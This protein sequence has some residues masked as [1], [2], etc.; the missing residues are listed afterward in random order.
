[1]HNPLAL[2][3][4][5]F[6]TPPIVSPLTLLKSADPA[7][8]ST[9]D[10]DLMVRIGMDTGDLAIKLQE[11]L[12]INY[13]RRTLYEEYDKARGHWMVSAALGLFADFVTTSNPLHNRTVWVT[14]DSQKYTEELTK[15]F[16]R[17]GLEEKIYDWAWTTGCYGDHFPK[18]HGQPGLG[19]TS[20]EDCFHPIDIGRIDHEG[21]LIGFY[22]NTMGGAQTTSTS[23]PL[24]PAWEYV[25]FRLLGAKK[26]R[27]MF[28]ATGAMEFRSIY[29]MSPDTRQ[30]MPKYGMYG[31]SL[32][33]DAL[34]TWKKLRLAEDSILMARLTR[35]ITRYIYK[36]KVSGD[37]QE[38]VGE[39]IDQ[40][41][42]MLKRARAIDTG[43]VSG[44]PSYDSKS[45]TMGCLIGSTGVR[46]CDGTNVAIK[47]IV[48]NKDKYIGRSVWSV[49]PETLA[50][51]SAKITRAEST[52]KDAQLIRVTL[53]NDKYIDCTPDHR[54]ML[55]D[56]TYK[57]AQN[58]RSNESIMP[59]YSKLSTKGLVGYELLYNPGTDK[60]RYAHQVVVEKVK[61]G[62]IRHHEDFNPLNNDP[63]NIKVVS[64]GKHIK[65][66]NLPGWLKGKTKE[67]CPQLI[68]LGKAVSKRM[69]AFYQTPRGKATAKRT[70][71]K[72][73]EGLASGRIVDKKLPRE[74]RECARKE[75]DNTFTAIASS[76]QKYCGNACYY[77]AKKGCDASWCTIVKAYRNKFCECGCGNQ[78]KFDSRY[79]QNYIHGH[80][81]RKAVLNHK[82]KKVEWLNNTEDTYDISVDRNFNFSLSSGIFVHNSMEDIILPVWGDVGDIS[83]DKI[84]GDPNI[85]WIVDID[86]LREQLASSLR[87]PVPLLGGHVKDAVGSLGGEALSKLDI[88]F[89]RT[90]KKLQR[91]LKEGI[92]RICQI[93]LAYMG[94]DPDVSLFEVNLSET[95]TAE[96]E[97]LK[98]SLDKGVDIID[99]YMD[100]FDKLDLNLDKS[101]LFNYLNKKI[102]KLNDLDLKDYIS[103]PVN[104]KPAIME[105]LISG[106]VREIRGKPARV[107]IFNMDF[108]AALPLKDSTKLYESKKT[109]EDAYGKTVVTETKPEEV[110]KEK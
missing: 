74:I 63:T 35:G 103:A 9:I 49:N 10:K 28:G 11:D 37:N 33:L 79:T 99:R 107:P 89:A 72:I 44:T 108:N 17:I 97:E 104:D 62:N 66:H 67:N 57:E 24:L 87:C 14:S 110:D 92:T 86:E 23:Q 90:A 95:S 55:R 32:V 101:E 65:I 69:K 76:N 68:E 106:A 30:M 84:G 75:C 93:H 41:V 85:R 38:A 56:G 47:D 91:A 50:I 109:W 70:G 82:V 73:R 77:V 39:M 18:I 45:N 27:S 42:S 100:M 78:F 12:Q 60:Y 52:R 25:H 4:N 8:I 31:T 7:G 96:E 48:C 59:F 94:M 51:E 1:M 88:R 26:K 98:N 58:L 2:L 15:L 29:L 102:L 54:F 3:K 71:A 53:D 20:I 21:M 61:R 22:M 13:E 34:P 40:Y 6:K 43:V 105:A 46:L 16:D 80:N 83:I 64:R 5:L 19:I 36:I 81:R